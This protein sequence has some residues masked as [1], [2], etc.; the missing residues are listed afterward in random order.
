MPEHTPVPSPELTILAA[1]ISVPAIAS[2]RQRDDHVAQLV[3]KLALALRRQSADIV[4]LPELC[5]IDYSRESF[6]RL[7]ELAETLDGKSVQTFATLARQYGVM[8]VVG[9]PRRDRDAYLISQ[10]VIDTDGAVVACYDKMHTAHYGASMEKDYFKPGDT[11]VSFTC[12]GYKLAPIICYDIRFPELTRALTVEHNIDVLLHSGAYYRD[13][14]FA[15]WHA[16]VVTRAM[17]NQ[18]YVV[19]LN[20]AGQQYGDSV[21]APPWVE[22]DSGLARSDSGP[23]STGSVEPHSRPRSLIHFDAHEEGFRWIKVERNVIKEV[24]QEYTFLLD[25]HSSYLS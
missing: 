16:F 3:D 24:R 2:K 12:K 21:V 8:V 4:V 6:D 18:I 23:V 7:P 1:Q 25:R 17:E 20:R 13:E 10:V 22:P 11:M 14:S 15:S 19:S 5:T 9:M